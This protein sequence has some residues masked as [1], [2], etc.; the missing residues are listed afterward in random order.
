MA[1]KD[2]EQDLYDGLQALTDSAFP[3]RCANCGREY[4]SP[5]SFIQ[6]SQPL[7]RGSGLKTGYDDDDLPIVELFRNCLCGSTLM[8]TFANRRDES[9]RGLERRR[10]FGNMLDFLEKKGM[11]REDARRELIRLMRGEE[12]PQLEAM[13]LRLRSRS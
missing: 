3:K 2:L 11:G 1:D 5:E 13:G 8:D 9:T 6:Q 12:S 4:E 7:G 10:V